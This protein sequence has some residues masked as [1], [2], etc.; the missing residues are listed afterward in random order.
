[1]YSQ[2][3]ALPKKLGSLG[4]LAR[5]DV[6]DNQLGGELIISKCSLGTI[7]DDIGEIV[8]AE[9]GFAEGALIGVPAG[10]KNTISTA[11]ALGPPSCCVA[12]AAYVAAIRA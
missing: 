3:G 1:M 7:N 5:L 4:K 12:S 6:E 2:A 11:V 9:A 8:S 10:A